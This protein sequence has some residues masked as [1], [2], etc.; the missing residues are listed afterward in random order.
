MLNLQNCVHSL[1][2]NVH[3]IYKIVYVEYTKLC[4]FFEGPDIEYTNL[5]FLV[6]CVEKS[7]HIK[8]LGTLNIQNFV[9]YLKTV[10][11]KFTDLC[12][13]FEKFCTLNIYNC[14]HSLKSLH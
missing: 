8:N 6:I 11:F 12:S 13:S 3:S 5:T 7:P 14:V 9:Y 1:K 2:N 4:T 10:C